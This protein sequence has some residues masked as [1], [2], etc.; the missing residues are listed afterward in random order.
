MKPSGQ[1]AY[2][3]NLSFPESVQTDRLVLRR[4]RAE[5]LAAYERIWADPAVGTALRPGQPP[6]PEAGNAAS[7]KRKLEHW[8]RHGFGPWAAVLRDAD[9]IIGWVG[10]THPERIPELAA[11]IEIAWTLREAFWGRGLATEGALAAVDVAFSHLAPPR[12]ISLI[13]PANH[14]SIGVAARLGMRAAG[15]VVDPECDLELR[16]YERPRKPS[17]ARA[18]RSC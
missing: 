9:E 5:D 7:L 18:R 11:E 2:K 14:N 17:E 16:I 12:V 10:A 3:P 8:Q 1:G 6:D 4:W 15:T 13:H